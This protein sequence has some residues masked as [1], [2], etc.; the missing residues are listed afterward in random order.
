MGGGPFVGGNLWGAI[1]GGHLWGVIC[2][3]PSVGGYLWG[4]ASMM[5]HMVPMSTSMVH[6]SA[7][8]NVT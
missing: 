4:G 3:R 5:T 1:C 8:P 7:R 2:G 6:V